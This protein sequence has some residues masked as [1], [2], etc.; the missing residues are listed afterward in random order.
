MSK[1]YYTA[2]NDKIF[3]EVKKASIDLWIERYPEATSP[4][5]AKEKVAEIEPLQNVSDNVNY[6]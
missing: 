4:Y 6:S 2:P 5:Y 1:L 3:E